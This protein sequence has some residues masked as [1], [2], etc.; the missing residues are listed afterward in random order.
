MNFLKKIAILFFTCLFLFTG[1][2]F[3]TAYAVE[4]PVKVLFIGNS[5]TYFH[6]IPSM[7]EK[8]AKSKG[9]KMEANFEN[10]K[11]GY[12]LAQHWLEG[13]AVK[14]IQNGDWDYVVLQEHGG[15]HH[16]ELKDLFYQYSRLFDG[17]IKKIGA[18]TVFYVTSR[19]GVEGRAYLQR[20]IPLNQSYQGIA[21][22]LG[23]LVVPVG[24]AWVNACEE[25]QDLKLYMEDN[26]HPNQV[27]AYF[28]A[29]VFYSAI[30]NKTSEG[31]DLKFKVDPDN[32]DTFEKYKVDFT[33]EEALMCFL[34]KTAWK[35]CQ[36]GMVVE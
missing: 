25:K 4:K 2:A 5:Y 26:L 32:V 19:S 34:Q 17:E 36:E 27:G 15:F 14:D 10:C 30:F 1:T 16:M 29:C 7:L 24:Q 6:S 20:Q 23:A 18:K 9:V 13:E 21:E 33:D 31:A 35:T 3:Q 22:E 28:T 11:P 12:S 8:I